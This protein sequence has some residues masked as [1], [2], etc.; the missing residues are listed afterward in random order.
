MT[1][2]LFGLGVGPGDP[3]LLTLKAA[4]ILQAVPVIAVPVS[5]VG[6][7]SYALNIVSEFLQ[8]EQAVLKLHFP[9]LK[10]VAAKR[11]HRQAAAQAIAAELQAGRDVAF[12][13]EGDPLLYSTFIYVLQY[14]A[15]AFPIEIVPGVSS[16]MAAAAQ[17]QLPLVNG[18]QRLAV[19]PTAF[20]NMDDLRRV[21][22]QFETVVLLKVYRQLDAVLNLLDELGLGEHVTLV[23][24]TSHAEGRVLRGVNTLRNQS[25]H[26]L[27]LM[28]VQT[29]K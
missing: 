25:I 22:E 20:E 1:G 27:S 7:E 17:A 18:G 24:R 10:E 29:E 21:L 11:A 19:L 16:I 4:R 12:L 2:T 28:I 26:Y 23:E 3:E 5:K 13:T 9:M 14:L 15:E 8:P 6:S